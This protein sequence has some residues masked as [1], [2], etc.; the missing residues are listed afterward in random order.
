MPRIT[1]DQIF[2]QLRFAT[3]SFFSV[4]FERRTTRPDG[5]AVAGDIRRMLC[6]TGGKMTAYKQGIIP[7]AQRDQEDF[8]HGLLTVWDVNAY[9][10]A[11]RRGEPREAAGRAAWRRIDLV[12]LHKLSVVPRRRLPP[13]IRIGLHQISNG[14]RLANMPRRAV[15]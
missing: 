10:A 3:N 15:P 9:M 1:V 12:T 8:T 13:D 6:R 11:I 2:A 4:E 7:D 14:F 5:T